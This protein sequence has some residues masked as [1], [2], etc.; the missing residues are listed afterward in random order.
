MIKIDFN[1]VQ[2]ENLVDFEKYQ[3]VIKEI[4]FFII[5]LLQQ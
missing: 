2:K 3:D 1:Y 4:A 5:Y